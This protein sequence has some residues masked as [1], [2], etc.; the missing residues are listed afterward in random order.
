MGYYTYFTITPIEDPNGEFD[1]FMKE[2]GERSGYWEGEEG[3]QDCIKWYDWD[4]DCK[5][6]SK[7][8][9]DLLVEVTGDGDESEDF[10]YARIKNGDIEHHN[11]IILYP[12]I[13]TEKLM[14][15]EELQE[16]KNYSYDERIL[17][18]LKKPLR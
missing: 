6:I 14:S 13:E 3:P 18:F 1:S 10:W 15:K 17:R 7:H 12:P 5:D 16:A 9:P 2:L 8:Y 4:G 11:A